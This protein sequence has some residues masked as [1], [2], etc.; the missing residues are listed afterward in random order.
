MKA[1][2]IINTV[3]LLRIPFS[4]YLLPVFLF[5]LSQV[6]HLNVEQA[7][8]AGLVLHFLVYPASNGY[9]SYMDQ[10]TESIGGIEKPPIPPKALFSVT[11]L[12]DALAL[13]ISVFYINLLFTFSLLTYIIAS[14]LYSYRGVRLKKYPISGFLTVFIFQGGFTFFMVLTAASN[15]SAYQ[16]LQSPL[17]LAALAASFMIGGGYPLTQIFQ[18]ESDKADNVTTL[19]MKLGY[20]GTFVFSIIMFA[21]VGLLFFFYFSGKHQ[22]VFILFQAFLLPVILWFLFWM[23]KVWNNTSEA[24]F[25]NAMRMN[26]ISALC[27]NAFF[28]TLLIINNTP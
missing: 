19:S 25:K 9:N 7:L 23:R 24:N 6:P 12:M 13:S 10:D 11:L 1:E 14:R 5:A 20:R 3:R 2:T 18:H 22:N 27:M 15:L 28:L 21:V 17:V 26:N 4:V 16:I 8:I